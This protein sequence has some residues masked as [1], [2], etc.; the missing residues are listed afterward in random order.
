MLCWTRSGV[1]VSMIVGFYDLGVESRCWDLY[2]NF[3]ICCTSS[4]E[5]VI[6]YKSLIWCG[7]F[8]G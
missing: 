1:S 5:I 2:E 8:T 4:L 6:V 7:V 3:L